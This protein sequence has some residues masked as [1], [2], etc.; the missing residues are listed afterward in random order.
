MRD[1]LTRNRGLWCFSRSW[2]N[3]LLCANYAD[4]HRGICLGFDLSVADG[5]AREV[6]YV[7]ERL[8]WQEPPTEEFTLKLL[9]TK[10]A[11]W[12]YEDEVRAFMTREE[13]ENQRY[14][15]HFD[16]RL[17]LREIIVGH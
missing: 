3:S 17:K 9:W 12:R 7:E 13:P 4:K 6:D 15:I 11:G 10:F 14:F 1:Q 16:D 8:P 2:T 5:T